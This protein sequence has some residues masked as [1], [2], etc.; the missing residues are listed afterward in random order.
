MSSAPEQQ[1][2]QVSPD[3]DGN[4]HRSPD[5]GGAATAT[6]TGPGPAGA[7]V[8]PPRAVWPGRPD[9]L[10]AHPGTAPDGTRGTYFALW[11]GGAEAVELCLFDDDGTETRAP[12]TDS[13]HE[14]WHGFLPGVGPGQRYGYRVH[15]RWDPWTGAR[16][17]PAKLLL[18]PYA[19][20][21]DGEFT[22]PPGPDGAPGPLP[23]EV[24]GHVRDWPDLPVADTVRDNRDSAP[25]VPKGVVVASPGPYDGRRPGT[26]WAGTVLYELHV[27][28]FTKRHPGIPPELRGTYAGL[29]HPAAVEYLTGLGVT[30][31]ELLPVHQFAHEEHLLRRGLVNYW[32][33]NSIGYFAPHGGYA[34]RGTRG[35]Q[36]REFRD[37]VRTLHSAGIEVILD[38]VY[39][40]TAEGNELG[41]TLSLRGIDN[42]RYYRLQADARRYAD[43]TG[44]GNTLHAVRPQALRLITDS[45]R[46]WVTELGVD[47]FRFDLASALARGAWDVDMLVPFLTTLAQ[48]PVLRRVKLIAEPWD[49][50]IGGYHVGGFP[51]GWSE[52]N[53]RFRNAVRDFWRGAS[54]DL[55]DL[56]YRLSGSSD[57]Y[58]WGGRAPYASVNFVTA[59]D[60]FTLRDLVSYDH[61]HN[62]ANGEENRDGTDDNRSWNCGTEGDPAPP[63]VTALRLRQIRNL[64]ATLLLSAGVP[65]LVAGDELGRTQ[66]GNN[67][68]YCQDNETSWVDWSLL[69]DPALRGLRTLAARLIALRRAHPGL[70]RQRFFSGRPDGPGGVRDLTWFTP[71]GREMT[72]GDWF[73]GSATLGM[74][75]RG[76]EIPDRDATGH[77][78]TDA[79]FLVVLHSGPD[80]VLFTLPGAPWADGYEVLADTSRPDGEAPGVHHASGTRI[81]VPGRTVLLLKA[82][83]PA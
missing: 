64:L 13:V 5:G 17:N 3:G 81:E 57:L 68:A 16:W 70:R 49:V 72:E 76:G 37:M 44:C 34:S 20:A 21:V 79:G 69:E 32:G 71:L 14:V 48:D 59:H 41:P 53:D 78:L 56:G 77:P 47:G 25:F 66:G 7:S 74:F 40:H 36:V 51:P 33:Y 50:G 28:G 18:D 62:E 19:R 39:N 11:A 63:E 61:K 46:Y 82:T 31:V 15:G 12:L 54:P 65:M 35:Q 10:G 58:A 80:P 42:G 26:P 83:G 43:C 67:N 60:G 73:A 1:Q 55:A 29:A 6:A 2:S 9:P 38:V 75:L 45:L 8:R 52:W 23:P 30:A 27:R 22:G 4:G 24:Y